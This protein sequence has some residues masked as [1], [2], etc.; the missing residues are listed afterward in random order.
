MELLTLE[1]LEKADWMPDTNYFKRFPQ[2]SFNKIPPM[3]FRLFMDTVDTSTQYHHCGFINAVAVVYDELG[4]NYGRLIKFE[5]KSKA[6]HAI[7]ISDVDLKNNSK[8]LDKLV[9]K[10][11]L[12]ISDSIVAKRL[13]EALSLINVN[14]FVPFATQTGYSKKFHGFILPDGLYTKDGKNLVIYDTKKTNNLPLNI[15]GNYD[16]WKNEIVTKVVKYSIPTFSLIVAFSSLLFPF[17]D[18][19]TI[20]VH[21]YGFSSRGKTLLLQLAASVFGNGGDPRNTD[22]SL[23][24]QWN[25]TPSALGAMAALYN[26]SVGLIDEL[27]KCDNKNF[28]NAIYALCGGVDKSRSNSKGDLQETKTWRF[29]GLSSG[30]ESGFDKINKTKEEA[31]LGRMIRFL[32]IH[33][34][35]QIFEG[36]DDIAAEKL[37]TNVKLNCSNHY[38]HAARDFMQQLLQIN[39]DHDKL[40]E[41][42]VN[43]KEVIFDKLNKP[44][45]SQEEIRVMHHFALFALAGYYASRFNILPISEE[46]VFDSVCYVRDIWLE[47]MKDYA[48]NIINQQKEKTDYVEMLRRAIVDNIHLYQDDN[49]QKPKANC[50]GYLKLVEEDKYTYLLKKNTF[51]DIYKGCNLDLVTKELCEKNILLRDPDQLKKRHPIKSIIGK[52]G[53]SAIKRLYTID[54]SITDDDSPESKL[55]ISDE[56]EM[57]LIMEYRNNKNKLALV[58]SDNFNK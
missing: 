37:A 27:H 53:K 49:D 47:H 34:K 20:F 33:I 3:G 23:I 31:T 9:K 10:G 16:T 48:Q 14:K 17:V 35:G 2:P 22:K 8:A 58:D 29:P 50:K 19:G 6:I 38:G 30:E 39:D 32:D 46:Q 45:L 42:I 43:E 13:Q 1:E 5:S 7:Y 51:E 25:K 28:P 54:S 41:L 12:L 11:Y 55:V 4:D 15:C 57:K 26:G 52:N 36:L 18:I 24:T 56:E 21:F 44:G 40:K